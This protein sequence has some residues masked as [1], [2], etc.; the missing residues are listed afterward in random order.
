MSKIVDVKA[1]EVLDSRGNPTVAVDVILE[2]GAIGKIREVHGEFLKFALKGD[3]PVPPLPRNENTP[4]SISTTATTRMTMPRM[5]IAPPTRS[6]P[7]LPS[8]ASCPA[9]RSTSRMNAPP[10]IVSRPK[11]MK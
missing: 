5:A 8:T 1:L 2:S 7:P 9:W 6:P 11:M 4:T 10:T 3:E